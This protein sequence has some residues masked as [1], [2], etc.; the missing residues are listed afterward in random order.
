MKIE[1]TDATTLPA[2]LQGHVSNGSLDLGA[3]AAPEDVTGLKTALSKERGNA[4]A[5]SKYGTPDEIDA[6]FTDLTEKARGSGKGSEDAQAKLDAMKADYEGKLTGATDRISKMMQRGAASARR[7][8]GS[9]RLTS[10]GASRTHMVAASARS[11]SA[12]ACARVPASSATS[13]DSYS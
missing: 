6:R 1:V 12:S 11:A 9:T 3:L 8:A 13:Y 10:S 2:W 5:Y 4:A 7:S